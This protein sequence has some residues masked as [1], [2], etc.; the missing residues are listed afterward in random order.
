MAA[1]TARNTALITDT[2]NMQNTKAMENI[3]VKNVAV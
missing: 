3:L 2:E 1:I